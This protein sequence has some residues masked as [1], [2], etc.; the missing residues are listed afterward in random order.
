M[1]KGISQRRLAEIAGCTPQSVCNYEN[2]RRSPT[3]AMGII[4]A[5]ALHVDPLWLREGVHSRE[6]AP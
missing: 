6:V 1:A 2:G 4:L 3:P 5:L